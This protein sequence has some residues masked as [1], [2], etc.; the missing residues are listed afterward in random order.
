MRAR[1]VALCV[2]VLSVL[3][4][5]AGASAQGS[6]PRCWGA[7]SRDPEH[8]CFNPALKD[9]VEPTPANALLVPLGFCGG[10]SKIGP[11]STCS[12]GVDPATARGTVALIGDS[13][14]AAL[15]PAMNYLAIANGWN[16]VAYI[17]NGC[18]FS[19]ALMRAVS[20]YQSECHTWAAAVTTLLSQ[21][22]QISTVVIS[23]AD[24]RLFV[25][26]AEVGFHQLWQSL[27]PSIHRIFIIRD[28]PHQALSEPDCVTRAIAQHQPAGTTC[29]QPRS[30]VL[31][32]DAEAAAASSA[33]PPR[34]HLLDFTPFFCDDVVCFPVVGG[35]LVLSDLQHLTRDFSL[36]LGPYLLRAINATR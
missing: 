25:G 28:V 9:V 11:I 36:S 31:S 19:D 12:F 35:V 5:V 17:H 34:V 6:V 21:Q 1:H 23:G 8:R 14:A 33:P 15:L 7:A 24:R 13:H 18:A 2:L 30:T 26:S 4:M 10:P 20:S 22:P 16:G 3:L 27:P 29:A 32:P